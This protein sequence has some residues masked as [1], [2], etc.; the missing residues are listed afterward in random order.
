MERLA[1]K[2]AAVV[3]ANKIART[4]WTMM[5]HDDRYREPELLL[6]A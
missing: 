4:A 6:A 5:V 3:L 2:V 1:I